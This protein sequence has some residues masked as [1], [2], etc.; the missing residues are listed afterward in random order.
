MRPNK[1]VSAAFARG[2]V[3]ILRYNNLMEN[4][5]RPAGVIAVMRSIPAWGW[6]CA[7]V[8]LGIIWKAVWLMNGA[9]PF[10]ADEAITGLMAR[11]IVQG[12]RPIFFYGQAYMGSLDAFLVA[13]L[14]ALLGESVL[15][16]RIVQIILYT[17][18]IITTALLGRKLAG[19]WE[20]G[21][22]AALLMAIPA[23]NVTL[24]TTVSLGG[25][26]E[27]LLLANLAYL[28]SFIL[29]ETD[30]SR[31]ITFSRDI[32][33]FSLVGLIT[34]LG[35]WVFGL[36]LTGTVPASAFGLFIL[37]KRWKEKPGLVL[38]ALLAYMVCFVIGSLP[39]WQAGFASGIG[40]QIKELAG[41]AVSIE[42]GSW[43]VRTGNHLFYYLFLG[44]PA[45]VGFRPPW[46]VRWLAL[47]LLPIVLM[48]WG[49][50]FW[51]FPK[52]LKHEDQIT[53]QRWFVLIGAVALLT[54]GF[55][56]TSFGLDPSGRYFLPLAV[57]FT[58]MAA[59]VI[60]ASPMRKWMQYLIVLLLVAY[61]VV[62][63]VQSAMKNPPGITTQFDNVTWIDHRY[64]G[65]LMDFLRSSGEVYGYSNYWVAYP[66]AFQSGEELIYSPR[67]PYHTD[68]RYTSRDDRI[69][70]YTRQV[71]E[72]PKTAYI[73]TFNPD[74]DDA[75]RNGFTRLG[76]T[77]Q[78]KVIGDYQIFFNLSQAVH[79]IDLES[80][81]Q[82]RTDSDNS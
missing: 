10:N 19:N 23:V 53:R 34:G 65:E 42:K 80:E 39:W 30:S 57:P 48:G 3:F 60:T 35:F 18:T 7:I 62:G 70:A 55:L 33:L 41:S 4:S 13:G 9:F 82:A 36:S 75:L 51:R 50:A 68:F 11:H 59:R 27:A 12:E 28:C 32:V 67:L 69:P 26:G 66:L 46:E 78:E 24:Y 8:I 72:S 43:L 81:L 56:F 71:E 52:L 79:P 5:T 29:S 58:L 1:T 31:Q 20:T 44:L 76:V 22:L 49:M 61:H 37:W 77:W 38:I 54:A 47:P 17:C 25:Y 2:K 63:T 6:L 64:D 14:F 45:A 21:L 73:T 15:P 40:L 74:L 16:I